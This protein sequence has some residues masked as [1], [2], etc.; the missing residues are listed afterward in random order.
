MNSK[1]RVSWNASVH[2][3]IR[4]AIAVTH[5]L[6]NAVQF[7]SLLIWICAVKYNNRMTSVYY[8]WYR[9]ITKKCFYKEYN[10]KRRVSSSSKR[11]ISRTQGVRSE[12]I[13]LVRL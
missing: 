7:N 8:E 2:N 10:F 1:Y 9:N 13:N 11:D 3:G 4:I 5:I 6:L 12:A